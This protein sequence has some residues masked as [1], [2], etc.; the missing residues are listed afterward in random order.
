M[1]KM[2]IALVAVAVVM[3]A[4]GAMAQITNT[5]HDFSGASW[6]T[7]GEICEPCHT[8]HNGDMSTTV[9][10]NHDVTTNSFNTYTSAT[11]NAAAGQP[12]NESLACLSCH[13]GTVAMDSFGGNTGTNLLT[14]S[15]LIGTDLSDDHPISITYNAGLATADG[16]L[17]NPVSTLSGVGSGNI[18]DDMLFGAGN[19]QLECASCHDPHGTSVPSGLLVKSNA[20]S[21]LCLTCHDK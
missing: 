16:E 7:G 18:D 12:A 11:M 3:A 17:H 9:L 15:T 5:L 21:D 2:M 13:D 10:W 4:S 19:D 14:G 6:N 1:K 20:G 8:P